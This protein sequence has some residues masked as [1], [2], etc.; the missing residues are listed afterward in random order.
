M[1]Q[2]ITKDELENKVEEVLPGIREFR[3]Q[4]H[5]KA[6]VKFH[7]YEAFNLIRDRLKEFP[8][9]IFPQYLETDT[10]ALLYGKNEGKNVTL[11]ADID[12]LPLKET[13]G[14]PWASET[15]ASHSCGHDGHTAM[16]M[17]AVEVL[18][19]YTDRIKGSV[20]FVFQPA[21]EEGGGGKMM[22][23]KGLLKDKPKADAV[24]GL[25]GWPGIPVGSLL[26]QPGVM[27]AAADRFTIVV[28]GRGGH[29]ARPEKTIDPVAASASIINS[30]QTIVSR[31][32]EPT[33]SGVIS[34]CTIH[35]GTANNVIPDEVVLEGT[36]RYFIPE[37]GDLIRRRMEEVVQNVSAAAGAEAD[38]DY[39]PGYI[40]LV[41]NGEMVDFVR[42]VVKKYLSIDSWLDRQEQTMGAEDFSFYLRDVPGAFI[43]L[44]LGEDS[45]DLHNPKFDFNDDALKAGIITLSGIALEMLA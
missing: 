6:S 5:R 38:F 29:G 19:S 3:H 21:E 23:E 12:A 16:L 4:L 8:L 26:S 41:N 14:V 40:P 42:R 43:R 25:H 37:I 13:S 44:G 39:R 45:A 15:D 20:R 35:G 28:R 9:T 17:G 36:T 32:I 30:L 11:R 27:M 22:V 18:E 33:Q 34:V 2:H 31:N 24:F 7:E 1:A 10:V